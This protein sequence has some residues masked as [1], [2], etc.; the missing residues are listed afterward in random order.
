[1][2]VAH[3]GHFVLLLSYRNERT[4]EGSVPQTLSNAETKKKLFLPI[5]IDIKS[6]VFLSKNLNKSVLWLVIEL[7][8]AV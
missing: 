1:M 2:I 3:P 7:K 6:L 4:Q 8:I 5:N